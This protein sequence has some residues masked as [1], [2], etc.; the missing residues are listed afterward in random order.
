MEQKNSRRGGSVS[1]ED[2]EYQAK[3]SRIMQKQAQS[4]YKLEQGKRLTKAEQLTEEE[5]AFLWQ[6]THIGIDRSS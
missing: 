6:P 5:Y 2:D 1:V 3:L 4:H